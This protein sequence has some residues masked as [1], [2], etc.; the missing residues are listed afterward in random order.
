MFYKSAIKFEANNIGFISW[1]VGYDELVGRIILIF[2][3]FLYV[4]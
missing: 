2:I 1:W 4:A 3:S